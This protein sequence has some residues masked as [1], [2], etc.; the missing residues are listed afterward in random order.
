MV[1]VLRERVL[2]GSVLRVEFTGEVSLGDHGIMR[3]KMVALV[4]ERTDP[5][6]GCEVHAREAVKD[7]GAGF[8]A[9][10]RVWERGDVWVWTDR[11]NGGGEWDHALAGFDFGAWPYVP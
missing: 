4:T 9:K 7:C 2:H 11:G 8:A 5:D 6:L 10:R 3:R 1:R